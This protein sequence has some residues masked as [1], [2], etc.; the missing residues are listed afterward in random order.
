MLKVA[1]RTSPVGA[2]LDFPCPLLLTFIKSMGRNLPVTSD[3]NIYRSAKLLID[4][5][6]EDAQ[7][8][9]VMRVDELADVQM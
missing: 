1:I 6:G 3:L 5:H 9:T 2:D 7:I 8:F 4:Q